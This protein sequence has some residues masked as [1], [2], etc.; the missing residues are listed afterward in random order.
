MALHA[1]DPIA[2]EGYADH[3]LAM[4][5]CARPQVCILELIHRQQH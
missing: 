5:V 1:V 2:Q 4:T 3:G